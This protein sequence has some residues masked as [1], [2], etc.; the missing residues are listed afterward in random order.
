MQTNGLLQ[1]AKRSF[2]SPVH[3]IEFTEFFRRELHRVKIHN[4]RKGIFR[5]LVKLRSES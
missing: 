2:N 1:L 5:F 3:G 4:D